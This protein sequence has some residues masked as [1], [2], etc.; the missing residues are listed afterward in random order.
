MAHNEIVTGD[1]GGARKPPG[2]QK[3][4]IRVV[5]PGEHAIVLAPRARRIITADTA[6]DSRVEPVKKGCSE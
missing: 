2:V 4:A 3:R 5:G 6:K 1:D